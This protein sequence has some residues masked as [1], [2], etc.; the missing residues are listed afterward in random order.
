MLAINAAIEASR[1]GE[2]GRGFAVVAKEIRKLATESSLASKE[3]NEL[4]VDTASIISTTVE[5]L[6]QVVLVIKST[7]TLVKAIST[8]SSEQ[9][10]GLQQINRILEQMVQVTTK[11][12]EA[13]ETLASVSSTYKKR[14]DELEKVV[15]HFKV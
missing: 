6:N 5:K 10:S 14:A 7:A 8:S 12:V 1:A 4:S 3:I 11:N 2:H 9:V 15:S 13:A